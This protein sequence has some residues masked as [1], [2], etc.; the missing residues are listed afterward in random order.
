M[1]SLGKNCRLLAM[2]FWKMLK[3]NLLI[4]LGLIIVLVASACTPQTPDS[5]DPIADQSPITSEEVS[6]LSTLARE[7]QDA[8]ELEQYARHS[9]EGVRSD[10]AKNPNLPVTMQAE[11]ADDES[12][13]VRN[14]L[15]A[16]KRLDVDVATTLSTDPEQRV[17]WTVALNPTVPEGLLQT[18]VED[19]SEEV[20]KK[21]AQNVSISKELMLQIAEKSK[22][23]AVIVLLKRD[24]LTDEVLAAI[25]ARPEEEIQTAL[26]ERS[27]PSPEQ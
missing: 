4:M 1:L 17:R 16:N 22:P 11:L 24:N 25:A 3:R 10:A 5:A 12:W 18:F 20:Q 27:S 14:Y 13:L 7:A 9:N 2:F 15:G 6:R 23:G 26:E 8:D 19:E 21:L